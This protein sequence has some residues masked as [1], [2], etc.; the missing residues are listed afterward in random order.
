MQNDR[1]HTHGVTDLAIVSERSLQSKP[2]RLKKTAHGGR[3]DVAGRLAFC[4]PRGMYRTLG[5]DRYFCCDRFFYRFK[6][7]QRAPM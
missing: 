6:N 7:S 5:K 2:C 4:D 3:N 1:L